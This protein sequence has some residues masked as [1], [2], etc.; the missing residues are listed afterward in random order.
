MAAEDPELLKKQI[1][2]IE[3]MRKARGVLYEMGQEA[4]GIGLHVAA[5]EC[6]FASTTLDN[7]L[8]NQLRAMKNEGIPEGFQ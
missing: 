1:A 7:A 5:R 8:N 3:R 2:L 4:H 6:D